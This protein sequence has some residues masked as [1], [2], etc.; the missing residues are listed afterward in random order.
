MASPPDGVGRASS[1]VIGAIAGVLI[2][3]TATVP[4]GEAGAQPSPG[5]NSG[6]TQPAQADNKLYQNAQPVAEAIVANVDAHT[7]IIIFGYI[8]NT[9]GF[10]FQKPFVFQ[11][12]VVKI[13]RINFRA[14]TLVGIAPDGHVGRNIIPNVIGQIVGESR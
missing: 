2:L 7:G 14:R 3:F 11:H 1:A 6:A 10:D 9:D 13:V 8:W 12:W 4:G 5:V